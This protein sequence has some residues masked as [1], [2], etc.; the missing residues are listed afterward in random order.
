[1]SP[2]QTQAFSR[3]DR[4]FLGSWWWT[5][6]RALLGSIL[7]L[8]LCGV[9]LVATASPPVAQ[10]IGLTD[11]YFLKRHIMLLS[12]SLSIMLGVSML[13]PRQVWRLASVILLGGAVAM[14][15]V[16]FFGEEVKGARRWI[17]LLGFSLQPSE[18]IKPAFAI[19]AAWLISLQ[20]SSG[21]RSGVIAGKKHKSR[22]DALRSADKF[23]G[24][25]YTI[26]MY[27]ILITLLLLQPDLGMTVVLTSV[28]AAQIV[29]AGLRLRFLAVLGGVG[30]GGLTLAYLGFHHVRSR[31]DRFLY[32]D[33]GDNYQVERSLDAFRHGGF[34]GTGP[35]Q[36]S[37][38]LILPDAHADF[39]FSVGGE[40]FGMIFIWI[41]IG[42]FLFTLL[43]GLGRL[44]E[45]GDMF[46]VLAVGGLLT[47]LGL[48]ALVHMGSAVNL[49]PAKGMTLPFISY[50]GSSILAMGLGMGMVL[51][52]T[53][54]QSRVSVSRSGIV[55]RRAEKNNAGQ[56]NE[57]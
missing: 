55:M 50:G 3:T 36:G 6:D 11:Y 37:E 52:L 21:T 31:I 22:W 30:A 14:L 20:K 16:L 41:L 39:I 28:F 5:V 10:R 47:M 7:A 43:R 53:R 18:F 45:N 32:P 23:P 48:Q 29:I 35:G 12:V 4:S 46:A 42:I 40:E 54:R 27:F 26:F 49:L 2:A 1:M 33:S 24:Y 15:M 17:S 56:T 34:W 13:S 44:R 38:K 8:A 9:I 51:A 57:D 19:V 25:H